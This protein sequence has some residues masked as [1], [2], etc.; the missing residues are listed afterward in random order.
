MDIPKLID[1]SERMDPKVAIDMFDMACI[2]F[3]ISNEKA[4]NIN[5]SIMADVYDSFILAMTSA[6]IEEALIEDIATTV[7]QYMGNEYA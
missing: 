7:A 1:D 4:E 3:G 5:W 6:G 2:G